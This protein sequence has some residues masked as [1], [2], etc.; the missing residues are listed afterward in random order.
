MPMVELVARM[1]R[2]DTADMVIVS[3][4][5]A[6]QLAA[7]GRVVS[8]VDLVESAVGIAVADGAPLPRMESAADLAAFLL[9]TPSIA[10]ADAGGSSGLI[11]RFAGQNGLT[12]ALARKSTLV[13][14]G[15][16]SAWVR[17][18]RTASAVEQLAEL[19]YGGTTNIVPVPDAVQVRS[20]NV[21]VVLEGAQAE[22]AGRIA[23]A[24]ASAEAAET[25][26]RA[27]LTPLIR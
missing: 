6:D 16:T 24:L 27:R 22:A 19:L 1:E 7:K 17:D 10:L 26:R 15:F 3:Q 4:P 11:L 25:Y 12:E 18:G 14:E 5:A 20:V 8:R 9:A 21:L 23:Q 13:H 2:G